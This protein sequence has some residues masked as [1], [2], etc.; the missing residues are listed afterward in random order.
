MPGLIRSRNIAMVSPYAAV[1]VGL[2]VLDSAWLAILLYHACIAYHV[3][4]ARP[5]HSRPR[6]LRGWK[7]STGAG[8]SLA[9][10]ACGPLLFVLWP[11][12]AKEPDSLSAGLTAI[13]LHGMRWRLFAA[14]FVSVHPVLEEAFW[15]GACFSR[16]EG[17]AIP[18]LAFAGYHVLVLLFFLRTPWLIAAFVVL[19][20]ISWL[21][22]R[23]SANHNGLAIPLISHLIAG[24]GIMAAIHLMARA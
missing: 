9:C 11:M 14:Y 22:R 6:L 1:L 15:R 12:I 13:G 21:W 20:A 8:I 24:L 4:R 2:H 3:F 5:D 19:S 18:D 23:T 16:R 7:T 17:V 10:A